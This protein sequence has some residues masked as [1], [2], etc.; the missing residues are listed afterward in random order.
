MNVIMKETQ[1]DYV[2]DAEI[3]EII[4]DED[5]EL[6]AECIADCLVGANLNGILKYEPMNYMLNIERNTSK[7]F[8]WDLLIDLKGHGISYLVKDIE[9]NKVVGAIVTEIYNP[10]IKTVKYSGLF[11]PYN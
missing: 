9:T 7:K 2:C 1:F 5:I 10:N 3:F 8:F 11:E 6:A 4:S